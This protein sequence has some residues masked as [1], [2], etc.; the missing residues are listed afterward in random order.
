MG[1]EVGEKRLC[2]ALSKEVTHMT[3]T[4]EDKVAYIGCEED[5]IW[6]LLYDVFLNRFS[7]VMLGDATI[8]LVCTVT[9]L[10]VNGGKNLLGRWRRARIRERVVLVVIIEDGVLGGSCDG[11]GEGKG[12]CGCNG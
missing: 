11:G 9:K 8:G 2:K 4:E 12:W 1:H 7:I 3:E 5:V 10:C 6:G